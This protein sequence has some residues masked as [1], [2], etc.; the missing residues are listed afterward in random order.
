MLKSAIIPL[1]VALAT[2]APST[3]AHPGE[4]A[5]HHLAEARAIQASHQYLKRSGT[6]YSGCSNSAQKRSLNDAVAER[7]A[8]EI[9]VLRAGVVA[10]K[11]DLTKRQAPS[12]TAGAQE[13]MPSGTMG[14]GGPDGNG[15]RGGNST[16]GGGGGGSAS[17]DTYGESLL[18]TSH[19]STRTDLT[20]NS[21]SSDLFDSSASGND[22][23]CLLQ[24]EV[25]IGPYWVA[26]EYV[27]SDMS[28][29]QS[30]IPIY[31]ST[32][33]IDVATCEPVV[34]L[35]WEMWHA[36]ASGVY[37]GVV[38][39]GNGDSTDETN[40]NATFCRGIQ[41]TDDLGVAR[42]QS[43]FVG[44]YGGRAQHV[45][46]VGHANAT[47]YSNGTIG[48]GSSGDGD[49]V[50][51]HI[52]QLF[53]DQDLLDAVALVSPYSENTQAFTENS[54]D[55]IL[56]QSAV[57]GASDPFFEYVYLGDSI[58][59]GIYAWVTVG[60]NTNETRTTQAASYLD[61]DG[62][63]TGTNSLDVGGGGGMGGNV[64]ATDSANATD[65]IAASTETNSVAATD[66]L[67][68]AAS[69]SEIVG[70]S[71]NAAR[72]AIPTFG[73]WRA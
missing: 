15:T 58:E 9:D 12:G 50:A 55:S 4:S 43:I 40:I 7:R 23:A 65:P 35:Y 20:S 46:V 73:Y 71:S 57:E 62:G 41:P 24:P 49:S 29:D 14:A 36:N 56:A 63:H 68:A 53:F 42:I 45:H 1:F 28:E 16:G 69:A 48:T 61:A 6:A 26:G 17:F 51:L 66:G 33:V 22:T 31:M 19:S 37:S 11:A 10:R 52:G 32:Q 47:V 38:A 18:N 72:R 27:R 21:T 44:H 54:E 3:M 30:G 5:E 39:S 34:G 25:T 67:V 59:D 8:A 2:L 70:S 64:T 13:S 60:I